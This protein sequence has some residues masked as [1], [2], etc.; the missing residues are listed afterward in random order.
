MNSLELVNV[1]RLPQT[2]TLKG[3]FLRLKPVLC[4]TSINCYRG[5]SRGGLEKIAAILT[6]GLIQ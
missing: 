6:S 2:G 1:Q 3:F 4:W 5:F